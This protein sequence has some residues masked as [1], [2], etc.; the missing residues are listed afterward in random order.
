MRFSNTTKCF[1]P[2]KTKYT[3]LPDDLIE[4]SRAE[5]DAALNRKR[6][7][8]LDVVEGRLV[9]VAAPGPTDADRYADAKG[10]RAAAFAA[11]ADPLFF[12][13]HAGECA[14]NEWRLKRAEI[15][16]RYPYPAGFG[17]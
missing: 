6:G 14:E 16:E 5:H 15:R 12:K 1:Y 10:K 9:V 2:E 11:E 17:E 8:T 13:W 3:E 7:E 4:V